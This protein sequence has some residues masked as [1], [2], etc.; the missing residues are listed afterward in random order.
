MIVDIPHRISRALAL[1]LA[2]G[3]SMLLAQPYDFAHR[4]HLTMRLACARCHPATPKSTRPPGPG[5][6]RFLSDACLDCHGRAILDLRPPLA[7]PIAHFSHAAHVRLNRTCESCHHGLLES[8]RVT[9]ALNP[10]MAECATCHAEV[11]QP[12]SCPLCHDKDDPRLQ[13]PRPAR[14]TPQGH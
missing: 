8:D 13:S 1:V 2:A 4:T 11:N 5:E 7:A 9:E 14:E 10:R 3:A 6:P 12:G